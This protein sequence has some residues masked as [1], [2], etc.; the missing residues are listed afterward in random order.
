M[1]SFPVSENVTPSANPLP[2]SVCQ[3]YYADQASIVMVPWPQFTRTGFT[4]VGNHTTSPCG[5]MGHAAVS[6][7][8][9][10]LGHLDFLQEV[11]D[12]ATRV[13]GENEVSTG[14]G[15]SHF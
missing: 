10:S 13:A 6:L 3:F 11:C 14:R 7:T 12:V 1:V 2:C 8:F 15:E 5:F 4:S 9:L